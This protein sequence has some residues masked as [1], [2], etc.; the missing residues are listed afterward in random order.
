MLY[1]HQ[2]DPSKK[3]KNK[4]INELCKIVNRFEIE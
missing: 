1:H 2:E 4:E 3:K